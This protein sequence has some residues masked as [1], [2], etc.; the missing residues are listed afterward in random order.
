MRAAA[1]V[2]CLADGFLSV[3]WGAALRG[4][5]RPPRA[6]H[7]RRRVRRLL[8]AG[9][10]DPAAAVHCLRPPPCRRRQPACTPR[11]RLARPAATGRPA[12]C[13]L[14]RQRAAGWYRGAPAFHHPRLQVPGTALRWRSRW[15]ALMRDAGGPLLV[16]GRP[17]RA[18]PRCTPRRRWARGFNQARDLALRLGPPVADVLRRTRYNAAADRAGAA[19]RRRANVAG[20]FRAARTGGA[21]RMRACN[22]RGGPWSWRTT[23]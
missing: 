11:R 2:R 7:P 6:A 20:A 21:F 4:V 14:A 22:R 15:P 10:A 17:G 16:A 23:C 8:A 12:P 13:P 5:R 1:G 19:G 18:R 9:R 3:V